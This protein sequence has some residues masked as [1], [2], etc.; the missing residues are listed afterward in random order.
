M[1]LGTVDTPVG[2]FGAAFSSVGLGRL[3]LP[4]EPFARCEAWVRRWLP[5]ARSV[6][7]PDRFAHLAEALTGYLAGEL[8]AF[9]VPLDLRGTPFQQAVWAALGRIRYGEVRTY[10]ALASEIG[11]PR[12]VRAVGAANG[13]NPVPIL[14]PCHRVIG[15]RGALVGYGGGLGL[16]ERL[17]RLEG[18][19]AGAT[20]MPRA[21]S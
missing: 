7:D 17:L 3:L 2:R 20:T 14:V 5:E 16:K 4:G 19:L 1:V 15:S 13:A 8:R 11:R 12:A 21:S 6:E 10:A 9:S 18:I